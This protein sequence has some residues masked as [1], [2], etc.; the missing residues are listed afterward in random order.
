M[1]EKHKQVHTAYCDYQIAKANKPSRVYSVKTET[2][3]NKGVKTT[4][5]SK[6]ML[7]MNYG[8]HILIASLLVQMRFSESVESMIVVVVDSLLR[9]LVLLSLSRIIRFIQFGN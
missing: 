2:K 4:G 9:I 3:G 1:S 5:L 8:I 6:A 7:R